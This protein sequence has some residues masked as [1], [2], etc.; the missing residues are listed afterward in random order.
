MKPILPRLPILISCMGGAA[1]ALRFFLYLLGTDEKGL[2]IA[3]HPLEIL[4]WLLAAA[5]AAL[6]LL[7]VRSQKDIRPYEENF[8]GNTAA[9]IGCLLFAAGLAVTTAAGFP[10]WTL[11]EQL[12]NITGLLALPALIGVAICRKMGKMPF[13]ALHLTVCLALTLH[14]ISHYRT[15]SSYP[16]LQDAFFPMIGCLLLMLFTYYQTTVDVSMGSRRMQLGTGLLAAFCCFAAI[17]GSSTW[18]LYLT[19]GFYTLTNL[20]TLTTPVTNKEEDDQ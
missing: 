8:P 10:A 1:C 20:C 3:G 16:Q 4:L 14:T 13:F 18:L 15:W 19:G 5:A 2:L 12:R 17:P 9:A 11:L 6:V 7:A